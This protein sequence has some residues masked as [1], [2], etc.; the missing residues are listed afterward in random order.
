MGEKESILI[1]DDDES[2]RRYLTLMFRKYG[3]ETEEAETGREAIEKASERFFN[4]VLLDI[5]LPDMEGT[6]LIAP[7]RARHL[8]MAVIL[9][10]GYA[11][12]ET[13][14]R[15]LHEGASAYITKPFDM[16]ELLAKVKEVLDNQRLVM[17][18]RRLLKAV[19]QELAER[20]RIEEELRSSRE[21]LRNLAAHI[22][23]VGEEERTCMARE[24]HDELGQ[25][26]TALKM[27]LSWF[28]NRL[29]KDQ[30]S[31][32]EKTEAMSKLIDMTIQTVKRISTELRPGLLD[33]LGLSAAIEWQA[34]E[35]QHRTGIK[36]EVTINPKGIMFDKA[37]ST[38]VFRIFQE[39]LTNV[40]RH[41]NA[42]RVKASLREKG[43]M[44]ELKV[45]DNGKGITEKQISDPRSFGLIGIRERVRPWEGEV[46]ILGIRN[47]GT[48]VTVI[49]PLNK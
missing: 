33:D 36:C 29:R 27:D 40:A 48:T 1:V 3:Y 19:Q 28:S 16:N 39:T 24:I 21:Q 26:M 32:H 22:Q 30:K 10:T 4:V 6:K 14:V 31:L 5:K 45:R 17:E 23:S 35:F 46:K 47:K 12:L 43:G 41:A 34:E 42:T 8:D 38:A 9:I 20:K 2:I 44:L 15:S 37:L 18:N 25:A 49:I 11:S 7:L 13:A